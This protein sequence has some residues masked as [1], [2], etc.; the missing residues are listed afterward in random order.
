MRISLPLLVFV[1]YAVTTAAQADIAS[2]QLS[3]TAPR[4]SPHILKLA[5]KASSCAVSR[6]IVTPAQYLGVINYSLPSTEKRLW[7]FD[8]DQKRLLYEELV[9]HGKNSGENFASQFSNE[10]GSLQ[11]SVGLFRTGDTYFGRNG[12]SLR[13]HGLEEGVNH[14]ALERTIVMHGAPYVSQSFIEQ[15]GRLGRSWGCPA[16][17]P[18]IAEDVLNILKE[19]A[20]LFVYHEDVNWTEKTPL[21]S[22]L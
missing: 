15:H 8:T 10:T 19:N 14:L 5:L 12:Y 1:W 17:R 11:S 13:L 6:G 16:V 7:I 22:C 9:A 20:F 4:L 2:E 18:E 21:Q 3:A